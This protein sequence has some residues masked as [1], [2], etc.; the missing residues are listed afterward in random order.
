MP[1]QFD[2]ETRARSLANC[3]NQPS[4]TGDHGSDVVL[5]LPELLL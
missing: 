4:E 5:R 1:F 2:S 3:F